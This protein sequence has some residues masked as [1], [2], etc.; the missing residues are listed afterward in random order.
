MTEDEQLRDM[1]YRIK[2]AE[3]AARI[4]Q[5]VDGIAASLSMHMAQEEATTVRIDSRLRDLEF[6]TTR[7]Q[8]SFEVSTSWVVT[9]VVAGATLFGGVGAALADYLIRVFH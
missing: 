6:R 5:K 3:T 2:V 7:T 9:L 1:Q 4:E 8:T